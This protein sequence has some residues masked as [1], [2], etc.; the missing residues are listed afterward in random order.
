M[1]NAPAVFHIR[2]TGIE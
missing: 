2:R 1:I